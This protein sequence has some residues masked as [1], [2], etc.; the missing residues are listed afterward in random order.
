MAGE[1]E[2]LGVRVALVESRIKALDKRVAAS[3]EKVETISQISVPLA[4]LE[5]KVAILMTLVVAELLSILGLAW[6]I[7]RSGTII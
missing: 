4:R 5:V 3:E 7:L 6:T 1:G 2:S